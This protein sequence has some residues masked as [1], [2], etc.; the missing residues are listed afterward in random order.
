MVLT[1]AAFTAIQKLP[2]PEPGPH[3]N[4]ESLV[5]YFTDMVKRMLEMM[6]ETRTIQK[7]I[8]STVQKTITSL[9]PIRPASSSSSDSPPNEST[10]CPHPSSLTKLRK[11]MKNPR[12]QF[13]R[14]EQAQALEAVLGGSRHVFLIGPTGMGKTSVFLIPATES[15]H[16]VTIVVVPLSALRVDFSRRCAGLGIQCS[17][18]KEVSPPETTIVMV[19]PENAA[20]RS[21]L[22]WATG[23]MH[24]RKALLLVYDEGHL[25]DMQQDFRSCFLSH[26][27]L[28]E[29]GECVC[30]HRASQGSSSISISG[31]PFLVMTAT[32]PP[33]LERKILRTIGIED[34]CVIRAPTPRPEISY[35]VYVLENERSAEHWL[36]DSVQETQHFY[37]PGEK[38]LIFCR[39]HQTTERLASLFD[40]PSF[41]RDE[42]TADE[43]R[44][45]YDR[46]VQDDN[47]KIIVATSLLGVGV[48]I[49]HVRNVW[50]FG[51]PWSMIDYAQETGRGGRDGGLAF[52]Y[53][54][55]WNG[56][57]EST[58]RELRY[59]EDA[60]RRWV[61]QQSGCRRILIGQVLDQKPTSCVLLKDSNLCDHCR[62][63]LLRPHPGSGIGFFENPEPM[64]ASR[65]L[66]P[67]HPPQTPPSFEPLP[68]R[69]TA[70]A[71]SPWVFFFFSL[72]RQLISPVCSSTSC[73]G[74]QKR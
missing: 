4:V 28:I 13:T 71:P 49:A 58:P 40:C 69:P 31:I 7:A 43:I 16:Q 64:T 9:A 48:D 3:A 67:P 36:W 65:A 10:I 15:P 60:L 70:S 12:A 42:R 27:R 54:V 32:C 19:S 2:V 38:G 45:I 74:V 53:L 47:Q 24:K 1:L 63:D 57:L 5:K 37:S 8:P 72:Q 55:T 29:T 21:F 61:V 20:K 22:A 46:F 41:H 34:C 14:P 62:E 50:H 52:S 26:R 23:M 68:P 59:T 25:C 66:P 73:A 44:D 17:E 30:P 18:W 6:E 11:F 56:E 51:V 35:N 39:S 33:D